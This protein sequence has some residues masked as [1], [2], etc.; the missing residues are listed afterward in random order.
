MG[1]FE[2]DT[3]VEGNAG[4]YRAELSRDWEIWGPN[5]GYMAAIALR[6]AGAL[7]QIPRPVSFAGHFLR[8]AKFD[9][10]DI[11]VEA[12][13]SGRRAESLRV[14]I[15]QDER[16][17]FEAIVRTARAGPGLEHVD[18]PSPD[19]PGPEG[20]ANMDE[21]RKEQTQYHKFWQNLEGRPIVNR[22]VAPEER[23]PEAPRARDWFRFRP[24]E[25][26]DDPFVDAARGLL[27]VDTM[28]WPAAYN[29]HPN[30]DFI[31]PSLD[32]TAQFHRASPE[33]PWLFCDAHAPLG[34]AGLISGSARIFD[35]EG[36][37][38]A[39]GGSQLM[40]VPNPG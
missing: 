27:L 11:A 15:R 28:L 20:L 6:A 19:V 13:Q 10:V 3:R 25:V 36:R 33:S 8:P 16:P 9:P 26:F 37:L 31:A 12:I 18:Y 38:V 7:A 30:P 32:L 34:E 21:L 35:I 24:R 23:V 4:V 17:V 39:S 2:I 40:C 29:R 22:W 5:G 14:R 1:D